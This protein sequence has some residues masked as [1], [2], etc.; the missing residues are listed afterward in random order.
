MAAAPISSV[1]LA[2]ALILPFAIAAVLALSIAACSPES[3]DPSA[4]PDAAPPPSALDPAGH[5]TLASTYSLPA[6]PPSVAPLLAELSAA[7][8]GVSDPTTYL[9]DLVVAELPEGNART[10][11]SVLAPYVAIELHDRIDAYAPELVPA[12]RAMALGAARMST[13]FTMLESLAV[14]STVAS[15]EESDQRMMRGRATRT[16]RGVRVDNTSMMFASIG[17]PDTSAPTAITVELVGIATSGAAEDPRAL[18]NRVT[19]AHH[20]IAL[21]VGA[22]FRA[23]FDR[24]VIPT[25]VPGATDLAQALRTLVDC[26]RL[27]ALVAEAVGIGSASLYAQACTVGLA[28]GANAIYARFPSVDSPALSLEVIGVAR[29]TDANGDGV[30]DAIEGGVWTGSLGGMSVGTTV[31]EG[32]PR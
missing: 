30:M 31:F 1:S 6:P 11:A 26:P 23:A 7:T 5:F 32:V 25:I 29:A 27:G 3:A 12:L 4:A 8:D 21:P 18:S 14:D 22:W 24:A 13:R 9:V 15:V 20:A 10:V 28:A 19:I 2:N 17:I 16:I